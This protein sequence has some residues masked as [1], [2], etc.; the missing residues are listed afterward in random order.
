[1][2]VIRLACSTLLVLEAMHTCCALRSLPCPQ[3]SLANALGQ[4]NTLTEQVREP[5]GWGAP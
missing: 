1:M 3:A 4:V 5:T 2:G